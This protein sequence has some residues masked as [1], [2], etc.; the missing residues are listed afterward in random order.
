MSSS[1]NIE[2]LLRTTDNIQSSPTNV[3]N[4]INIQSSLTDLHMLFGFGG[5]LY[6]LSNV[7]INV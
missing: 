2:S 3:D 6:Y 4:V 7:F 5:W 1:F